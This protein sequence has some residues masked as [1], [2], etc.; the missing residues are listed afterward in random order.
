MYE[1]TAQTTDGEDIY[2]KKDFFTI[3]DNTL[4]QL[5]FFGSE[6]EYNNLVSE[7]NEF[8]NKRNRHDKKT[9]LA[10]VKYD[11]EKLYKKIMMFLKRFLHVTIH[12]WF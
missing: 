3:L 12:S 7:I 8:V 1:I 5:T 4:Y 10:M 6:K 2:V 11:K 9:Q